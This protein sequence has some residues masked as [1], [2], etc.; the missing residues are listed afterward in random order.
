[1]P[2]L[3]FLVKMLQLRLFQIVLF[4][5][6]I[7]ERLLAPRSYLNSGFIFYFYV[8][9]SGDCQVAIMKRLRH[10]NIVLFMGAVTEPPKLSIVTE[11]L[12]RFNFLCSY[13]PAKVCI[14]VNLQIF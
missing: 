9:C 10:P 13:P 1:M 5:V 12:S 11:Y 14:I 4:I 6:D 3:F 7:Y 2:Q 8:H